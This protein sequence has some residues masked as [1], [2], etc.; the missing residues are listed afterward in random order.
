M[1]NILDEIYDE[2]YSSLPENS[3]RQKALR[4]ELLPMQS[5]IQAAFGL[6]FLDRLNNLDADLEM[7][8]RRRAFRL[9]VRLGLRAALEAIM[10]A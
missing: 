9:G 5:Q 6:E 4:A 2:L 1:E 3:D 10:P 7:A 8:A